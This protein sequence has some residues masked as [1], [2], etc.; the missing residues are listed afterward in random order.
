MKL[1]KSAILIFILLVAVQVQAMAV[2]YYLSPSGGNFRDAST[3]ASTSGGSDSVGVPDNTIDCV[4]DPNSGSAVLTVN[5]ASACKSLDMTD[6]VGTLAGSSN[7]TISGNLTFGSGQTLNYTGV[8][9]PNANSIITSNT[10]TG[11]F[12]LSVL[13]TGTTIQLADNLSIGTGNI[14]VTRGTFTTNNN[15]IICS[16]FSRGNSTASCTVN[17][18]SSTVTCTSFDFATYPNATFNYNTST[19]ILNQSATGEMSFT[20]GSCQFYNLTL[21]GHASTGCYEA[22]T[23]DLI[24]NNVLTIAGQSSTNKLALKSSDTTVRTITAPTVNLSNIDY[25]QNI[26]GAGDG[27]I[28][29]VPFFNSSSSWN[30]TMKYSGILR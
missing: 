9:S 21:N 28:G 16:G 27:W 8:I 6:F 22:F 30:P 3:W 10:K 24:I 25:Y 26:K 13:T 18:G 17:L 15:S 1:I 20:P 2:T 29:K 23:S 19:I 14:L 7:F 12:N 5:V 11:N 4:C